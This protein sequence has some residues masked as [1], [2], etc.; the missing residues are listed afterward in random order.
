MPEISKSHVKKPSGLYRKFIVIFN[1]SVIF[2]T[3]I[4]VAGLIFTDYEIFGERLIMKKIGDM[5]SLLEFT[6]VLGLF[7]LALIGISIINVIWF[8]KH[9]V[10]PIS[11]LEE[12]MEAIKKGNFEKR[13][14][15]R[16]GDEFQKI[17]DTF[18]Q[19]MDKISTLIQTEEEKK[20]IQNSLINFLQLLSK[21]SEGDLTQRAE[22]TPDI[23][24]SLADAFNIMADGL[25][26]LVKEVKKSAEDIGQKTNIIN[27]IIQKLQN[28]T[29]IQK[30]QID[31]IVSLIEESS[32]LATKTKDKS[33]I[34]LNISK[35]AINS[36]VKGNEI[37]T[38]TINSMQ[39]INKAIN[40]INSRMKLLSEKIMEI[41]TASEL[42]SDIANKTNLLALN[43]SIEAEKAGKEGKG[44]LIIAE[45][46]K[47]IAEKTNKSSKEIA[48]LISIIQD[49][50]LSLSKALE[51]ETKKIDTGTTMVSQTP[52]VFETIDSTIKNIGKLIEEINE[53][54]LKQSEMTEVKVNS[55][56]QI[57]EGTENI[58]ELSKELTDI[59][60]SMA[61]NSNELIN[62]IEK[63][64][65]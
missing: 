4:I 30:E 32:E 12:S 61:D 53:F 10:S 5:K 65:V 22:V 29:E 42:I 31:R 43:A 34:A 13:I 50:T 15:L 58:N 14:R 36:I 57:K 60:N 45:E 3:L 26:E 23:F 19:M 7:A 16:T 24:G 35:E 48:G 64:R 27:E 44:F 54:A 51:E 46:I 1:L 55:A 21:A 52:L 6:P 38:E 37:V 40:A 17:G 33:Q 8:K 62:S 9:I 20:E 18:N 47:N 59:S 11:V 2:T 39:L 28:A 63:F 49:E 25:S 41:A 56:Q